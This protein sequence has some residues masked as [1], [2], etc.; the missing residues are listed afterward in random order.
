M[1]HT[2]NAYIRISEIPYI[3]I[4]M[5]HSYAN[6]GDLYKESLRYLCYNTF[7]G[8]AHRNINTGAR[9]NRAINVTKKV[10]NILNQRFHRALL[11]HSFTSL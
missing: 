1:I 2:Y 11:L 7:N 5:A 9:R 6:K 3:E 8:S 10:I 4:N